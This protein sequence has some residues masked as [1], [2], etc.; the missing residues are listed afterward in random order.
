MRKIDGGA[1]IG[2]CRLRFR[3]EPDVAGYVNL[4]SLSALGAD[5]FDAEGLFH[6]AL[7]KGGDDRIDIIETL[8]KHLEFLFHLVKLTLIDI[9]YPRKLKQDNPEEANA[10]YVIGRT[11]RQRWPGRWNYSGLIS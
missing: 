7:D 1:I 5:H 3:A 8:V 2:L 6:D 11:L 10:L 9:N 4:D